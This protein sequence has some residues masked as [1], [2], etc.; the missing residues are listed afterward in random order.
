MI[1]FKQL[2][3]KASPITSKISWK[4]WIWIGLGVAALPAL[5][6][7]YVQEMLAA[8]IGFSLFFGVI[9]IVVFAIFLLVR[10]GKPIIVSAKPKVGRAA[11]WSVEAAEGVA[12][13]VVASPFWAKAASVPAET[14]P[15]W[16]KTVL[17]WV[18]AVPEWAKA[19]PHRFRSQRLK[20]SENCRAVYSRFARLR[21]RAMPKAR[22]AAQWSVELAEGVIAN[23]V[24]ADAAFAPAKALPVWAKTLPVRAKVLPDR[25]GRVVRTSVGVV[26]DVIGNPVWTK[27]APV[28][29]K[30]V[31][32]WAKS[33]PHGFRKQ[34]LKLNEN[35]EMVRLRF[36]RLRPS[37]FYRVSLQK[38]GALLAVGLRTHKRISNELGSW[39]T[40]RVNY[41]DFIRIR[42]RP[43]VASL[44]PRAEARRPR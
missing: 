23:P 37:H 12:Q 14:L 33:L 36:A 43:Q 5:R 7:F 32:V 16:A 22:R 21:P 6:I 13:D 34:Q 11:Q 35:Y 26:E 1:S 31:P 18:R 27:A 44:R 30:A 10:V 25:F 28:C 15:V 4:T 20:L 41:S 2:S 29:A 24:W 17:M 40:K 3:E 42:P 8:L 39:L 38:G 9:Y 19:V